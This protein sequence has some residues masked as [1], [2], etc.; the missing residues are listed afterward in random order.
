MNKP[1]KMRNTNITTTKRVKKMILKRLAV[2]LLIIG[3]INWGLVGI[4]QF[5]A[6]AWICGGAGKHIFEDNFT[7]V[8]LARYCHIHGVL[9]TKTRNDKFSEAKRAPFRK[10]KSFC[11][12][13]LR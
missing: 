9:R 13:L 5:N 4:F 2:I 6:V 1:R 8:G 11:L 7:L 3:G 12:I 10:G